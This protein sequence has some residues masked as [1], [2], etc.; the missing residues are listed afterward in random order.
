MAAE[1]R[2]GR[3]VQAAFKSP[4]LHL[5]V[6]LAFLKHLTLS[7]PAKAFVDLLGHMQSEYM[8]PKG[9]GLLMARMLAQRKDS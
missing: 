9:I 8:D 4:T 6:S 7:P 3:L 2:E 1:L 5:D